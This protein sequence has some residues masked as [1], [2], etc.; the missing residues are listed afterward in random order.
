MQK[1]ILLIDDDPDEIDIFIDAFRDAGLDY[2]Y[3][4]AP[5]ALEGLKFLRETKPDY[6][7][8]DYKMPKMNGLECLVEIKKMPSLEDVPVVMYS[9]SLD[10]EIIETAQILGV[11]GCVV[12]PFDMR[13]LPSLLQPY[14]K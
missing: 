12:K 5:N 4:A 13:M 7:V 6:I 9:S 8:L 2:K 1:H 10:E 11:S 3:D 14:L